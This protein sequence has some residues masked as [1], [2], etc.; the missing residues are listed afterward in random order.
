VSAPRD[1]ATCPGPELTV[2]IAAWNAEATLAEQ[3]DALVRQRA[4]FAWEVVV[5]DNGSA[6]GT[7]ALA[8]SYADRLPLRVVDA[9]ATRGAGAARNAGVA[10]AR[11]PLVAFCDAD[12]VVADDWVVAVR[13]ALRAHAFVAG[14]FEGARLNDPRV[15]RSRTLPQQTGL[16][17][18]GHLPGLRAAG[19]GN[20]G[21]RAEVFRAVGGFDP[22]C[23]FLE[24]TDL[25]W[26]IQLAGVPLT[27]LPEAVVHVRLRAGLRSAA[28]QGYDYGTGERWLAL[29]YREQEV[30]LRELAGAGAAPGRRGAGALSAALTG[31]ALTGAALTDAAVTG[32][33]LA[34]GGLTGGGFPAGGL[35]GGGLAGGGLGG[36][37]LVGA[38]AGGTR[39]APSGRPGPGRTVRR[40][41]ATVGGLARVRSAGDLGRWCWDVGWG[42]GFAFGRV[43]VPEPVA[44]VA[45]PPGAAGD[46]HAPDRGAEPADQASSGHRL[47]PPRP[48]SDQDRV[49]PA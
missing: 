2:V 44:V 36:A 25:C 42:V 46:P 28:R 27:W 4:P 37:A 26:R 22:A 1:G 24:D 41:A 15:L 7:A 40:A 31:A 11:A 8:R 48:G 33:A 17:D 12:D 9:A 5:A 49:L 3:L 6:D 32:G 39:T 30:R 34:A 18:S 14:R 20:M 35:T 43:A 19:A 10:A 13:E 21:V 29:R 38:V 23:R 16:Q 45:L 47:V